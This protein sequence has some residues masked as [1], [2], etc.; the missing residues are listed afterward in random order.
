M[1]SQGYH[2]FS[3]STYASIYKTGVPFQQLRAYI[4]F[5]PLQTLFHAPNATKAVFS[6]L[7]LY[8]SLSRGA[9]WVSSQDPADRALHM[10]QKGEVLF[11]WEEENTGPM[12]ISH[13][14]TQRNSDQQ[15]LHTSYPPSTS[16]DRAWAFLI[17]VVPNSVHMASRQTACFTLS[18]AQPGAAQPWLHFHWGA[19][20]IL[21][22]EIRK[23][24][25]KEMPRENRALP[26]S[27]PNY[28][29]LS[30]EALPRSLPQV[31]ATIG[32]LWLLDPGILITA[33]INHKAQRQ[34]P[35]VFQRHLNGALPASLY[36]C[37]NEQGD[38]S[39]MLALL[40][41]WESHKHWP[42]HH[43]MKTVRNRT[44]K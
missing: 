4:A 19:G 25:H 18:Q 26:S 24:L 41:K 42:K 30:N 38:F 32:I 15:A 36:R 12:W 28:K 31:A 3:T 17:T 7:F 2:H 8:P 35:R 39:K 33:L 14:R 20:P 43:Q 27:V 6:R 13:K 44:S 9:G 37:P 1:R 40:G 34:R 10:G 5:L 23:H 22:V 16:W 21:T 11:R 29:P